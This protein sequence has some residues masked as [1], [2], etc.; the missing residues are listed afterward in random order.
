[1]EREYVEYKYKKFNE[2]LP[3]VIRD[4]EDRGFSNDVSLRVDRVPVRIR[5]D[6]YYEPELIKSPEQTSLDEEIALAKQTKRMRG[7]LNRLDKIMIE[8]GL[9]QV[10]R[11]DATTVLSPVFYDYYI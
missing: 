1:M 4:I 7:I 5:A 6:I 11:G 8:Y 2:L 10:K 3:K 9:V